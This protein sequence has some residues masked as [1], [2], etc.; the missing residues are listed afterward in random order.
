MGKTLAHE[1]FEEEG[2]FGR[3][4]R[5]IEEI[6]FGKLARMNYYLQSRRGVYLLSEYHKLFKSS[7]AT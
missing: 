6:A 1:R 7:S 5:V 3:L 2:F 4:M